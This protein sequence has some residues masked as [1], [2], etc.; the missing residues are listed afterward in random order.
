VRG[1]KQNTSPA[2]FTLKRIKTGAVKV[3]EKVVDKR[4]K[5][6]YDKAEQWGGK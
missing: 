5:I 3:A 1:G 2:G 4:K 6:W